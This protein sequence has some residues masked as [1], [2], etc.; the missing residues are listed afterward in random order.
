MPRALEAATAAAAVGSS[1]TCNSVR[2]RRREEGAAELLAAAATAA[3]AATAA[4]DEIMIIL[5]RLA[6]G[7]LHQPLARAI[8]I[9]IIKMFILHKFI[10]LRASQPFMSTAATAALVV[11]QATGNGISAGTYHNQWQVPA[12]MDFSLPASLCVDIATASE[13]Q[14]ERLLVCC[15]ST[16]LMSER[17]RPGNDDRI[18]MHFSGWCV[19]WSR[20]AHLAEQKLASDTRAI[21]YVEL[22]NWPTWHNAAGAAAAAERNW[23]YRDNSRRHHRHRQRLIEPDGLVGAPAT[24]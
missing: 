24:N 11:A 2:Q 23:L 8:I 6:A 20:L 5:L 7:C 12:P 9:I 13:D 22:A 21:H 15:Y 3:T 17:A 19:I 4:V 1:R 16:R 10:G 14:R 18:G